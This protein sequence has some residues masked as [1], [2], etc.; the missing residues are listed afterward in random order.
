M[1][2]YRPSSLLMRKDSNSLVDKGREGEEGGDSRK[3]NGVD[4]EEGE[5]KWDRERDEGK[6]VKVK[7]D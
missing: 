7:W 6:E 1:R 2:V 4:A 5:R 3:K